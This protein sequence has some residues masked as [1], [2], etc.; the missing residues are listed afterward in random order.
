MPFTYTELQQILQQLNLPPYSNI[1]SW[2]Y[3]TEKV[4]HPDPARPNKKRT[5]KKNKIH[6]G[7]TRILFE[8]IVELVRRIIQDLNGYRTESEIRDIIEGYDYA[9][10]SALSNHTSNESSYHGQSSTAGTGGTGGTGGTT[11][12]RRL[13]YD[14]NII[15]K[16][17]SGLNIYQFRFNDSY[18]YGGGL[19]QGVMSDEVPQSIVTQDNHGYDMV[20]YNQ[21]DVNFLKISE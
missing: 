1:G 13:K 6:T 21:I 15:G 4:Q 7:N 17:P 3:S 18:R 10:A 16:S 2:V 9:S 8:K 19:Y 12:D 11:S 20:D 5:V 14:L